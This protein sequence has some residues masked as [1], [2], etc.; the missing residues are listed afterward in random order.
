MIAKYYN[1]QRYPTVFKALTG[2]TVSEFD[3]LVKDVTPLYQQAQ[4]ERHALA[5]T[6]SGKLKQRQRAVG[7]GRHCKL[8]MRDQ[9]LLVVVWLR[10][11]PT[12]E[13]LGFL[14][15]VSDSVV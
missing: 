4:Q 5:T 7:G 2:L 10:K 3:Q 15:G 13:V 6:P 14:F 1:L 11:Y 12:N 8:L 9:F